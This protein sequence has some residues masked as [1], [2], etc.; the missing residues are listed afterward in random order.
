MS[1]DIDLKIVS[2][3]PRSNAELRRLCDIVTRALWMPVSV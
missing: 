1:E 3:K 2:D